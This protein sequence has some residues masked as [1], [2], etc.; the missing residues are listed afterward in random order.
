[1]RET[2]R[3]STE[4]V[5]ERANEWQA[6]RRRVGELLDMLLD[7]DGYGQ[8]I[9]DLRIL[10]RGQKE[11]IVRC[12]KEYRY[13]VNWPRNTAHVMAA[14]DFLTPGDTGSQAHTKTKGKSLG[15]AAVD[16]DRPRNHEREDKS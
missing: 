8:L 3:P 4:S 14:K 13:V 2:R 6:A 11:V 7:H 1:M 10:K 12:G 16:A 15:G 9:V 5:G